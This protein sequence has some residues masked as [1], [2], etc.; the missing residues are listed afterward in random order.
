MDGGMRL[1]GFAFQ[2]GEWIVTFR[3]IAG[4]VIFIFGVTTTLIGLS[5]VE[6]AA[7]WGDRDWTAMAVCLTLTLSG[8][9]MSGDKK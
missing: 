2:R 1:L 7:V 3:S 9:I 4:W 5:A 8:A 6:N